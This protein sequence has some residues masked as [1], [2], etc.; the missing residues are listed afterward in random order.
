[1]ISLTDCFGFASKGIRCAV[2][3]SCETDRTT[4]AS[5]DGEI[6]Y[7]QAMPDSSA[8]SATNISEIVIQGPPPSLDMNSRIRKMGLIDDRT[9]DDPPVPPAD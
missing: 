3:S 5:R 9:K 4:S 6:L 8:F 1:M 7:G 2:Y